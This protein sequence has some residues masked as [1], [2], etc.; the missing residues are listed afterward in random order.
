MNNKRIYCLLCIAWLPLASV[1]AAG[2]CVVQ[3]GK[4]ISIQGKVDLRRADAEDWHGAQRQDILCRGD[5]VRVGALSRAAIV[6][7]DD[8]LL[9]LDQNTE[10]TF[11]EITTTA[12]SWLDLLTGAIHLI[13]RTPQSL[14]IKTPFVNAGVEGTEFYV[15]VDKDAAAVGVFEGTVRVANTHGS[16]LLDDGQAAT[17]TAATAPRPLLLARPRDA[18]AWALYYP[19]IIDV[20]AYARATDDAAQAKREAAT[21]YGKG[22][23]LQAIERLDAVAEQARDADFF[24]LRAALVL[25]VGRVEEARTDIAAALD[26][27]PRN[28]VSPALQAIIAVVQNDAAQALR[29]A[30]E[31]L[32]RNAHSAVA[33]SALSYAEQANLNIDKAAAHA[34]RA[35]EASP[36]NA[37]AWARLAELRLA[38]G[39]VDATLTAAQQA[40]VLAPTLARTLAVL[41]FAELT[42]MR[43]AKAQAYFQAAIDA[44][45]ADPLP[46][47]GL[48]LAHIRLGQ[49]EEGRRA[50]E[51][52]ASLDPNSALIRSYLGKAYHEE[53]RSPLAADQFSMAKELDPLDPTPWFYDAIRKQTENDPVEALQD[54]QGAITRNDNR[55][56]YRSSLLLD[57]D[58]AARGTSIARVYQDVGFGQRALYEG[59]RS[60]DFDNGNYSAH[61][62]LADVYSVLPRH[63]VARVSELLQSQ[64]LQ[65]LNMNP[66]QPQLAEANLGILEGLGPST[67]GYNEFTPLF[68]RNDWTFQ[69]NAVAAS[70]ATL[71]GD[72]VISGIQ[73]RLSYS[74]GQFYYETDGFRANNDRA[75]TLSTAF[76]QYQLTP[77]TG[78]QLEYRHGEEESG[79]I[80]RLFDPDDFSTNLRQ[81]IDRDL[82]RA[83]LRYTAEPGEH[84]LVNVMGSRL[85]GRFDDTESFAS[86]SSRD[87]FDASIAEGQYRLR[88]GRWSTILGAG[89]ARIDGESDTRFDVLLCPNEDFSEFLSCPPD[90]PP[91]LDRS[92]SKVRQDNAYAYM[93]SDWDRLHLT[94]GLAVNRLDSPE[95]DD[96]VWNPKLGLNFN[97]TRTL[98]LRAAALRSV[99]RDLVAEQTLEPTELAGFN[100]FY[101]DI[102]ATKTRRFGVGLDQRI[103][104]KGYAGIEYSERGLDVPFR[105]FDPD[106]GTARAAA[107]DW[108][109]TLARG[110][111]YYTP[112]P[113]WALTAEVVRERFERPRTLP[114]DF[115]QLHTLRLP[116]AVRWF[117]PSG[118]S[119]ELIISH[120][121]QDGHFFDT[122]D[123]DESRGED[124]VWLADAALRYRLPRRYG[125]VS[126]GV[127]NLFDAEY[128]YFEVD[129]SHPVLAPDRVVYARISV[130]F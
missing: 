23:V 71:G 122:L 91:I 49:L 8:T 86:I 75:Q 31:A 51:I 41:G 125:I 107:A 112:A 58:L 114:G 73:Q 32:A 21:L 82:L 53:R 35:V 87:E 15:R 45:D 106:T 96:T 110:Y 126:V 101:D 5:E 100:Q 128:R 61:R 129:P 34:Q 11:T 88:L 9:R 60:L 2:P 1:Y 77:N 57:Q 37:L 78:V 64:L 69:A 56:V 90:F 65:P 79:D 17:A 92:I 18:V 74:L 47:L 68:A 24:N 43:A 63:E 52:A 120:V 70:H 85:T 33:Y 7:R 25:S 62:L 12:P 46:R 99:K 105:D 113:A 102:S 119:T 27:D 121:K 16:L 67:S 14:K 81:D 26:L 115:L 40:A 54:L 97:L 10:L 55:A 29:L 36:D 19:P 38:Q 127:K 66:L 89:T 13:T 42:H 4:L 117:H 50:I 130:S 3:A 93:E 80:R 104:T 30:R 28:A 94:L 84:L 118:L 22:N 124:N 95:R 6:L 72:A 108:D 44:D 39:D 123:Q 98:T 111:L 76:A 109:E 103:G 83:G 48:G 59:W 20:S 116:L